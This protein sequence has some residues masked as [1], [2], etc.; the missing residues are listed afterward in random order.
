MDEEPELTWK[1]R[2][3]QFAK[4]A[5]RYLFRDVL[6][7]D[8]VIFVFV[9]F[10]F[11]FFGTLTAVALSERMFWAGMIPMMMGA[12]A[13]MATAVAGRSFGVPTFIRKPEDAKKLLEKAPEIHA[14]REKRY[15]AG[16]RL[17]LIGMGCVAISALIEQLFS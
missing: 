9:L 11:L 8:A 6:L 14:E 5:L 16:A 3:R 4:T 13:I 10:S 12:V 7:V 1:Q 15:N 17:W 2:A